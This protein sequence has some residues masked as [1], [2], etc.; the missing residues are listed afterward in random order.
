MCRD[1]ED[2]FVAVEVKRVAGIDAVEQLDRYLAR[3][4]LDPE[5]AAIR[6]LLVAQRIKPQAATL[7]EA[8]GSAASRS[9]SRS[10]A[11]SASPS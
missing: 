10:S 5:L 11:A 7:A 1:G 6:G 2:G 8:R 3:L 4:R 9:T